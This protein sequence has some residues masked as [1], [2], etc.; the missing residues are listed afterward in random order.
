MVFRNL[1]RW[2]MRKQDWSPFEQQPVEFVELNYDFHPDWMEAQMRVAGF[3]VRKR[4]G[5]S[6]F[7]LPQIKERVGAEQLAQ[8]DARLFELG[9]TYPV[10]PSVFVQAGAPGAASRP[11]LSSAPADVQQLFRCP[12]CGREGLDRIDEDRVRCGGCGAEYRRQDGV[13][14]LK[15]AV[16]DFR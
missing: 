4:Y 9:G 3:L 5:V 14:D 13:W 6:H 10:S 12:E 16:K 8:A 7:R 2:G 15:E 1:L 11:A